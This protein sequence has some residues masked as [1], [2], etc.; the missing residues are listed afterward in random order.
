MYM[1]RQLALLETPADWKLDDRTREI[2]RRG[3]AEARAALRSALG[4]GEG[5]NRLPQQDQH[6][7]RGHR[8]AA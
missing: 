2:G 3:V 7:H 8:T 5:Q 4:D 1:G 6:P